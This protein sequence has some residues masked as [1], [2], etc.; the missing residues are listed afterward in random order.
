[1]IG[2]VDAGGYIVADTL[3]HG[4]HVLGARDHL[5]PC[6]APAEIGADALARR[7]AFDAFTDRVDLACNLGTWRERQIRLVLVLAARD[8]RVEKIEAGSPDA[9]PHLAGA[10]LRRGQVLDHEAIGS[11]QG[12]AQHR[13]HMTPPL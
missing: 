3:G 1:S 10:R 11:I 4:D 13:S 8:E 2:D 5:L 12:L 9:H 6:T 7:E